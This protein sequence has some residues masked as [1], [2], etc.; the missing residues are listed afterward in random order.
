V[1]ATTAVVGGRD[2]PIEIPE[3][4]VKFGD[5]L[6]G[7][8]GQLIVLIRQNL[9]DYGL[10]AVICDALGEGEAAVAAIGESD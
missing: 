9:G 2:P 10:R 4:L 1:A 3:H 6:A 8:G 7:H 5:R